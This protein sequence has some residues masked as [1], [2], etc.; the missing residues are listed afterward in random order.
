MSGQ[1][2]LSAER[3]T[4]VPVP[5]HSPTGGGPSLASSHSEPS[6]PQH[7]HVDQRHRTMDIW[8][9]A[10]G[11]VVAGILRVWVL[12]SFFFSSPD[13]FRGVGAVALNQ[14]W[15]QVSGRRP[16]PPPPLPG[17]VLLGCVCGFVSTLPRNPPTDETTE[18][19]EG[20]ALHSSSQRKFTVNPGL[21]KD[22]LSEP[23][24]LARGAGKL[25]AGSPFR[26]RSLCRKAPGSAFPSKASESRGH[27]GRVCTFH[28]QGQCPATDAGDPHR[29]WN[30]AWQREAV[31]FQKM[32]ASEAV[33]GHHWREK[34]SFH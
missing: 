7:G 32:L 13:T 8:G 10:T 26:P 25:Q 31:A 33:T 4:S 3:A 16:P 6:G 27:S 12:F 30:R 14:K 22:W 15:V 19:G 18:L 17:L 5:R 9:A 29:R 11:I 23:H 24:G 20:W 2:Q 21:H 34:L 28:V 1:S